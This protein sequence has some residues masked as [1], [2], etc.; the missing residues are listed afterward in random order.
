[1]RDLFLAFD[2]NN[3]TP[4]GLGKQFL[5]RGAEAIGVLLMRGVRDC[6]LFA[7]PRWREKQFLK[8][9]ADAIGVLL[10]QGVRG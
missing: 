7:V 6:W 10:M 1:M 3:T 2:G 8:R 5:W 9:E 4:Q